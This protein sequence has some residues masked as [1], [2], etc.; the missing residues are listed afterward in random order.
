VKPTQQKE[1]IFKKAEHINL[2]NFFLR[3]TM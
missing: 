3:N 1:F 2:Y